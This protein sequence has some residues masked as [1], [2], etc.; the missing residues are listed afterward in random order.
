MLIWGLSFGASEIILGLKFRGPKCAICG[1]KFGVGKIIWGL[2]FPVC[3]SHFLCIKFLSK[4]TADYLRSLKKLVCIFGGLI[5]L[6]DIST[7]VP[8]A[9]QGVV[10][11]QP[12][13]QTRADD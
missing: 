9:S 6:L 3:P 5:K 4:L 12:K 1:P 10:G 7:P 2:I 13:R 8:K 11:P